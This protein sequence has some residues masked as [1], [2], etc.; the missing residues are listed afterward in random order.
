MILHRRNRQLLSVSSD[1]SVWF[2]SISAG[3]FIFGASILLQ[4]AIYDDWLHEPGP[5]R[6]TGSLLAAVCLGALVLRSQWNKREKNRAM[7]E[8]L[9]T[10]RWMNDRIR[11][12]LQAIEC[13]T[14]SGAPE[15][16]V[17]VKNAVDVVECILD[18]FLAGYDSQQKLRT[19]LGRQPSRQVLEKDSC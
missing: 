15:A 5:L 11:N 13:V 17:Q 3:V 12:S 18:D 7:L 14:Y 16:T 1:A 10:I 19:A 9:E 6:M 4:W 8:R 2:Y